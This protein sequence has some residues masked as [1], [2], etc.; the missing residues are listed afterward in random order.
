MTSTTASRSTTTGSA[1]PPHAP[2]AA[3]ASEH[4][5]RHRHEQLSGGH[6][7]LPSSADRQP[8]SL[9]SDGPAAGRSQEARLVVHE[10]VV[11]CRSEQRPWDIIIN[12]QPSTIKQNPTL[13]LPFPS[14]LPATQRYP[15]L[16]WAMP[17]RRRPEPVPCR[18]AGRRPGCPALQHT[19]QAGQVRS[20]Q[21]QLGVTE[22]PDLHPLRW[23]PRAVQDSTGRQRA[24]L[25][26]QPRRLQTQHRHRHSERRRRRQRR[27]P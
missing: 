15:N 23:G 16:A 18:R 19:T 7:H 6:S 27:G 10:D 26:P 3:A 9:T 20:G 4:T 11:G 12:H 24:R 21:G 2:V 17:F 5:D 8:S 22:S 14:L 25:A 1:G 13:P